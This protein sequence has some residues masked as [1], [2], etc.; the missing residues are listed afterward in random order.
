MQ[1]GD[2]AGRR[3]LVKMLLHRMVYFGQ[4]LHTYI[5]F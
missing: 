1:N 5:K 4:I 2:E 3:L